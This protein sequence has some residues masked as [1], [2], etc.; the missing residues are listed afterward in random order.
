MHSRSSNRLA[1]TQVTRINS[2]GLE[3]LRQDLAE[4]PAEAVQKNAEMFDSKYRMQFK[5]LTDAVQEIV[6]HEGDRI[7][8]AIDAGP[9]DRLRDPVSV[10]IVR[11]ET[12]PFH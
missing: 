11:R 12:R 2:T 7:I 4:T 6:Q 1:S 5:L 3:T 10:S 8:T 9:H